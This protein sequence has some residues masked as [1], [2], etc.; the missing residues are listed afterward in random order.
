[1]CDVQCHNFNTKIILVLS[2]LGKKTLS[3]F[4]YGDSTDVDEE[5]LEAFPSLKDAGRYELLRSAP[6]RSLEIIPRPADG[7]TASY[8][9]DVVQQAKIYV[10]P[11]QRNLSLQPKPCSTV[12]I[13][14]NYSSEN[15]LDPAISL[16]MFLFCLACCYGEVPE[17]WAGR[18]TN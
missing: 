2:G 9:K 18:T 7:Y 16:S 17:L 13:I 14:K 6:G 4:E 10:R 11:I 3:L 12:C 15:H 1:M 8:L 5:M